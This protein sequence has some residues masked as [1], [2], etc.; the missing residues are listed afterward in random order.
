MIDDDQK[1]TE[2]IKKILHGE[3]VG[4]HKILLETVNDFQ[5]GK[6]KLKSH[7]YDLLILDIFKGKPSSSNPHRDGIKILRDIKKTTFIPVIFFSGLTKDVENLKTDIIRVV[8]KTAG[9]NKA[10]L[11]EIT[12]IINTNIPLI[13]KK[14]K[15]H[16]DESMR[17][18]FWDFVQRDWDN[19]SKN[20]DEV[21]LGYLLTRRI[22][23]SF[24]KERIKQILNDRKISEETIYPLEYYIYPPPNEIL[25]TGDIISKN[26]KFYVVVTPSCDVAQNKADFIHLAKCIPLKN[27]D[28]FKEYIANRSS[29]TKLDE[30]KLILKSN[31]KDRYF[32]LPQTHFIDNLVIDFQQMISIKINEAKKYKRVAKL[33]S[34][35]SESMTAYFLRH[36]NRVGIEDLNV[37][38]IINKINT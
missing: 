10:L 5:S 32:F 15:N 27:F 14:L 28:E 20:I 13:K 11:D 33:D 23:K 26:G 1:N 2:S 25:G 18:Y 37:E 8:T 16:I 6:K 12:Q 36:Y 7:D 17:S 35:F 34:P 31:K 4:E 22:A 19:F 21:S 9:G 30:L 3:K 38:Y 29:K 24:S